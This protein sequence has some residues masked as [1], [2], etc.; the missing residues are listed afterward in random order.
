MK[1]MPMARVEAFASGIPVIGT[2]VGGI[3]DI[4]EDGETGYVVPEDPQAFAEK[5]DH[6]A[7]H[8]ETLQQMSEAARA[9]TDGC[10]WDHVAAQVEDVYEQVRD[11]ASRERVGWS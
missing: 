11:E 6:L 7:D 1:T 4:V 8:P 5:I 9:A 2:P 10:T 3:P